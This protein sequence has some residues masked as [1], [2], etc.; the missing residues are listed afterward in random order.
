MKLHSICKQYELLS[1]ND[2][3][4]LCEWCL[5]KKGEAFEVF[6]RFK[7]MVKTQCGCSIKVLRTKVVKVKSHILNNS[8]TKSLND[9]TLEK[10]WS[11]R[12]L[13]ISHF[14]I[15]GSLYF[16]HKLDEKG[17]PMIF[18]GYNS[19]RAYKLYSPTS[20]K[21]VLRKDVALDDSKGWRWETTTENG[22]IT[23][24]I[25]LDIQSEKYV[26]IVQIQLCR[27]QRTRQ[28]LERFED[29]TSI[30]DF[31][32]TKEEDMMHLT[33]LVETKPVCFEQA[34]KEPE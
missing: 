7:A 16:K 21:V 14:R 2:Q 20:K 10:V 5:I 26:E 1:I 22:N 32:V 28:P 19:T 13:A 30:L 33:L 17:Q 11:R 3:K 8:P 12:K 4:E 23:I 27:S 18:L 31:E 6:K 25:Q 15:F 24:L 9:V 29:Y 34:I